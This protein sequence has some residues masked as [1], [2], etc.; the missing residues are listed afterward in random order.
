M[1][2]VLTFLPAVSA[3]DSP[4]LKEF[5]QYYGSLSVDLLSA[6]AELATVNNFVYQKDL[7][8]FTFV[9]GKIYL[10]RYLMDRPTTAI[11]IGKGYCSVSIPSHAERMNMWFASGDTTVADTFSVCF[12][13]MADDLDLRL[14]E[15][16]NFTKTTIDWKDY[17]V[18]TKQAQ[19][20]YYFRPMLG[21]DRDN[22]FQLLRSCYERKSDGYFWA[23]FDRYTFT[24]DPNRPEQTIIAYEKAGGDI[25]T[26]DGAVLQRKERG[27]YDDRRLSDILYHTALISREGSLEMGGLN[28][29]TISRASITM[30]LAVQTDSLRFLTFYLN[31]TLREDSIFLNNLPVDYHRRQD[32]AFIGVISPTYFH[33][34]DTIN[35]RV[36]YHGSDY[37]QPLPFIENPAAAHV[38]IDFAVPKGYNFVAPGVDSIGKPERGKIHFTAAPAQPYRLFYFLAYAGGFDTVT[39]A[40]Q[41]NVLVHFLKSKA[42]TKSK[43]DCY[44]S[45]E[46]YRPPVLSAVDFFASRF[47]APPHAAELYVY[48]EQVLSMPGLMG[49]PQVKCLVEGRGGVYLDAGIEASRQWFGNQMKIASPRELWIVEGIPYYLGLMSIVGPLSQNVFYSELRGQRDALYTLADLNKDQPLAADDRVNAAIRVT[50]GSWVFHMLRYLMFDIE[51]NT[52]RPFLKFLNEFRQLADST[53]FTNADFQTLAEKYYGQPLDWFSNQWVYGRNIPRID[54]KSVIQAQGAQWVVNVTAAA[55]NVLPDFTHPVLCSVTFEDGS[56][57]L[58]MRQTIKAG[59]NTFTVG[60]FDKKPQE[61]TFNEFFSMLDQE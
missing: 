45:D 41:N 51:H 40:T 35:L 16:F 29:K 4:F 39:L 46:L 27:V 25:I 47:G 43:F 2:L 9:E 10:A 60:P 53:S 50:K 1:A 48:P 56:P 28:G 15:K 17:N 55:K 42:I 11:F 21:H 30:K 22:Y 52:D 20:E 12:I 58:L 32:F 13:R 54:V 23:D 3:A 61:F 36:C 31:K 24:F 14:K 5:K 59:D 8:T 37:V 44:V 57:Q 34:G 26:V 19:G 6:P 33:R 38:R 7:A 49:V 18:A